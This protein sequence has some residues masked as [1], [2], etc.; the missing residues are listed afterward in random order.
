M[1]GIRPRIRNRRKSPA[2]DAASNQ[3]Q[4]TVRINTIDCEQQ[5]LRHGLC[6]S[7]LPTIASHKSSQEES[8]VDYDEDFDVDYEVEY[9]KREFASKPFVGTLAVCWVYCCCSWTIGALYPGAACTAFPRRR[10]RT[11]STAAS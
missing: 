5:Q 4:C 11:Q 7:G 3:L 9:L 10:S 6:Y 1:L 2:S 8:E